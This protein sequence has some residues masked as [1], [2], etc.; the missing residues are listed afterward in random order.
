M[1]QKGQEILTAPV[2][3]VFLD[4]V[5]YTE[6][7]SVEAQSSIIDVLDECVRAEIGKTSV[8]QEQIDFLPTGRPCNSEQRFFSASGEQ[9]IR[10]PRST[11]DTL[12]VGGRFC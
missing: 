2:K 4:I 8:G 9:A 1:S 12:V 11:L 3:Y 5:G 6:N 10:P 7:R